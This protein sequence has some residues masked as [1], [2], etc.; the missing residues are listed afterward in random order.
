M[1]QNQSNDLSGLTAIFSSV[2][3]ENSVNEYKGVQITIGNSPDIIG[4]SHTQDGEYKRATI[5]DA[6]YTLKT[7]KDLPSRSKWYSSVINS[8]GE[9]IFLKD[10]L[11]I[12][13]KTLEKEKL[14]L[15]VHGGTKEF[16]KCSFIHELNAKFD[17]QT[18][19]IKVTGILTEPIL[20]FGEADTL[21]D[22]C[23]N[24]ILDDKADVDNIINIV[25]KFLNEKLEKIFA[26]Y[27]KSKLAITTKTAQQTGGHPDKYYNLYKKYKSK[28]TKLKTKLNQ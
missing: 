26:T 3:K 17:E 23:L 16:G 11:T 21:F 9:I 13:T 28:Y 19:T 4:A 14:Y 18:K 24:I 1:T 2:D 25:Q 22:K 12:N 27:P 15:V 6:G 10:N 8:W 5:D 20:E 7:I